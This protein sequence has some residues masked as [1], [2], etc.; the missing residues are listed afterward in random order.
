MGTILKGVTKVPGVLRV[1]R[2]LRV[3]LI[4]DSL[5]LGT[6]YIIIIVKTNIKLL[7]C[8]EGSNFFES[9]KDSN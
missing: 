5:I 4:F 3:S 6:E 2:V 9:F 8:A 7:N 1:L